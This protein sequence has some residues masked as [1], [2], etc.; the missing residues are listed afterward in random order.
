MQDSAGAGES[1]PGRGGVRRGRGR[2]SRSRRRRRATGGGGA[3]QDG[4]TSP[5]AEAGGARR[6][7]SA[8]RGRCPVL[9]TRPRRI[10]RILIQEGL[11]PGPQTGPGRAIPR[12]GRRPGRCGVR[13]Q[14]HPHG[15]PVG[16]GLPVKAPHRRFWPP[17]AREGRWAP[18][19]PEG[20]RCQR[21]TAAAYQY[22]HRCQ[23]EEPQQGS[24]AWRGA[25]GARRSSRPAGGGGAP[26]PRQKRRRPRR[27]ESE[28]KRP[29]RSRIA[30][31]AG[32]WVS[33]PPGEAPGAHGG[34]DQRSA[35][36]ELLAQLR[37]APEQ[38]VGWRWRRRG[39][40]RA[41]LTQR[42]VRSGPRAGGR[43]VRPAP[44][45]GCG[46]RGPTA[47]WARV[48]R[49]PPDDPLLPSTQ[50]PSRAQ[51]SWPWATPG[52]QHGKNNPTPAAQAAVDA[53]AVVD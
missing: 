26:R 45:A 16:R 50:L 35:A 10:A 7:S 30:G 14:R 22:C 6:P 49:P 12:A 47:E 11:Q 53:P 33:R 31:G 27:R 51:P 38:W 25:R 19:M 46:E 2:A 24:A 17:T 39:T 36:A 34:R 1:S 20:G 4:H 32:F 23:Q 48:A 13:C 41:Q 40:D 21:R 29:R 52:A 18:W 5:T 15:P 37:R 8:R 9:I 43:P 42:R 44:A 3:E 28:T